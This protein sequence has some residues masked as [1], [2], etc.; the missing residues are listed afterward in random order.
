VA[1]AAPRDSSVSVIT[2]SFYT[3]TTAG[4]DTYRIALTN[5]SADVSWKLYSDAGF[6]IEVASCDNIF[7]AT[8][9]ET[10]YVNLTGNT[11]Y[12]LRVRGF[13]ISLSSITYMLEVK[14]ILGEG[15]AALP[16]DLSVGTA[17]HPGSVSLAGASYYRFLSGNT[18]A[19]S[20][21]ITNSRGIPF[22]TAVQVD[23]YASPLTDAIPV[24]IKRC[25]LAS[26]PSC[27]A[28]GLA[29]NT[30]HYVKVQDNTSGAVEYDI[31][32]T[33]GVSEGSVAAPVDLTLGALPRAAAVD[34]YDGRSY[35][36]FTSGD[37]G[38]EYLL[39]VLNA[40][41]SLT[42]SVYTDPLFQ[43]A[44]YNTYCDTLTS[45]KL[46]LEPLT[47]YYVV[48][49]NSVSIDVSYQIAVARGL[50]E[51]T[52]INPVTLTVGTPSHSAE[53]GASGSAYY[54]FTTTDFSGS[55]T[56]ALSGTQ[57]DLK[58][59]VWRDSTDYF[60]Q[61]N[62]TCDKITTAGPGDE[63]CTKPN[64]E[65]NTSYTLKVSNKEASGAS[66]YNI[67]VS[68]G[69]GSEGHYYAPLHLT[70]LTRA[71]GSV[72]AGGLSYYSFTTGAQALTYMISVSNMQSNL[73]WSISGIG[74]SST[75]FLDC[76]NYLNA[77]DITAETCATS[78]R[79]SNLKVLAANTTY[80]LRVFNT[81]D[82]SAAVDS[83]F[84]LTLTPLDPAAGCDVA[85]TECFTFE[86]GIFPATFLQSSGASGQQ[87][88]WKIDTAST[89]AT[90]TKSIRTGS[91]SYPD[92]ACFS[93]APAS[94]PAYVAFSINRDSGNSVSFT[95]RGTSGTTGYSPNDSGVATGWRRI[96]I[97]TSA[98]AGAM[99]LEWCVSKDSTFSVGSDIIW[100]DDIELK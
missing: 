87:W 67:A 5:P 33:S 75:A 10:C 32:V 96:Q 31:S 7:G 2:D 86:D 79:F 77:G 64:M 88:K 66:P 36:R 98:I 27:T 18:G 47:S 43:S 19:Y 69:G 85:A 29:A 49:S 82:Y 34:S 84:N 24:L 20:I 74:F 80:Y 45:C 26:N 58:W 1:I 61:V 97:D 50:T 55:Y 95:A 21:G 16:V 40:T 4:T 52:P 37:L 73:S 15:T 48:V 44:L 59:Q 14:P 28:N 72:K 78:D 51:G 65:P 94:N 13:A 71:G 54:V 3:F 9:V 22:S 81:S 38:G 42:V 11:S 6:S 60:H 92:T 62:L 46:T 8:A 12:Y 70:G 57:K 89:A 63:T 35:Y 100:L 39:S 99:T 41:G 25:S 23:I 17:A 56:V 30:N 93:Y 91:L 68:A 76:N 53:I 83:T 90:G